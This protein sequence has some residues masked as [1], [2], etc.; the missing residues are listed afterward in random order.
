MANDNIHKNIR[1][2]FTE[3]ANAIRFKTGGTE[4]IKADEFPEAINAIRVEQIGTPP[5]D[6]EWL[7]DDEAVLGYIQHNIAGAYKNSELTQVKSYA[8][9]NQYGLTKVSFPECKWIGQSAFQ[10]CSSLTWVS[11]LTCSVIQSSAFQSC[12]SLQSITAPV[13]EVLQQY[14]F[15]QCQALEFVQMN[16]VKTIQSYAFRS[17]KNLKAITFPECVTVQSQAFYSCTSLSAVNLMKCTTIQ[18]EAF[19]Y[20]TGLVNVYLPMLTSVGYAAFHDCY[21]LETVNFPVLQSIDNYAFG[22][23][24]K[25]QYISLYEANG[26]GYA[27]FSDCKALSTVFMPKATQ[28]SQYMFSG[29]TSLASVSAPQVKTIGQQAF[30]N[31]NVLPYIDFPYCTVIHSQAFQKNYALSSY[32]LP[33]VTQI[34]HAAFSECSALKIVDFPLVKGSSLASHAFRQNIELESAFFSSLQWI[35]QQCFIGDWILSDVRIP[36]ALSIGSSAFRYCYALSNAAFPSATTIYERAFAEC[37]IL[38]IASF[39]NVVSLYSAAFYGCWNLEY[40]SFPKISYI[41]NDMFMNCSK[42]SFVNFN[43]A[44]IIGNRA[45]MG[46]SSLSVISEM[47]SASLIGL[48]AFAGTILSYVELPSLKFMPSYLFFTTETLS[49]CYFNTCSAMYPFAMANTGMSIIS[50]ANFPNLKVLGYYSSVADYWGVPTSMRSAFSGYQGPSSYYYGQQWGLEPWFRQNPDHA[51]RLR[52]MMEPFATSQSKFL[53]DLSSSPFRWAGHFAFNSKLTECTLPLSTIILSSCIFGCW[54]GCPNLELVSLP[55]LATLSIGSGSRI[56]S[57]FNYGTFKSLY[58]PL[59]ST[60]RSFEFA[61]CWRMENIYIPKLSTLADRAFLCCSSLSTVTS[62]M[63]SSVK[64]IQGWAFESC[65]NLKTVNLPA[66]TSISGSAFQYCSGLETVSVSSGYKTILSYTFQNCWSLSTLYMP[67]VTAINQYAFYW[68]HSLNPNQSLYFPGITNIGNI[69]YMAFGSDRN[70]TRYDPIQDTSRYHQDLF[71]LRAIELPNASGNMN[72][73]GPFYA[74]QLLSYCSIPLVKSLPNYAF[75]YCRS[76]TTLYCPSV[77]TVGSY[78][79]QSCESLED[80]NLP[81]VNAIGS[82][83]FENCY[84]LKSAIYPYVSIIQS[85]TF[86]N[87]S[88]LSSIRFTQATVI[89]PSAFQRCKALTAITSDTFPLASMIS[90]YAFVGCPLSMAY[91]PNCWYM[92]YRCFYSYDTNTTGGI[93]THLTLE[94][95]GLGKISSGMFAL[96]GYLNLRRVEFPELINTT[97]YLFYNLSKLT[98]VHL[99]KVKVLSNYTFMSCALLGTSSLSFSQVT[100]IGHMAFAYCHTLNGDNISFGTLTTVGPGSNIFSGCT[101]FTRIESTTFPVATSI[102]QSAFKSMPNLQYVNMPEVETIAPYA[103]YECYN[104]SEWHFPKAKNIN[105]AFWTTGTTVTDTRPSERAWLDSVESIPQS[106]G[107]SQKQQL[108]NVYAPAC[109]TIGPW[110]F[111]QT[112]FTELDE[113]NFPNVETIHYAAFASCSSLSNNVRLSKLTS[114]VGSTSWYYYYTIFYST[115]FKEITFDLLDVDTRWLGLRDGHPIEIIN[116]PE[117]KEAGLETHYNATKLK[118]FNAPKLERITSHSAFT[119]C[120]SLQSISFPLCST[121]TGNSVFYN[122]SSLSIV[123][124]P[125]LLSISGSYNF[126]GCRDLKTLNMPGLLR[127]NGSY[128]FYNCYNLETLNMPNL[129]FGGFC[130]FQ[131][132]SALK[133]VYLPKMSSFTI[134]AQYNEYHNLFAYCSNI[135]T[136][137]L[138]LKALEWRAMPGNS[139]KYKLKY[140]AF[141]EAETATDGALEYCYALEDFSLPKLQ[142]FGSRNNIS[143]IFEYCSAL[144]EIRSDHF[145]ALLAN[146]T[147]PSYTFQYCISLSKVH[148]ASTIT[149]VGSSAFYNCTSLHTVILDNVSALDRS[150]FHNCKNLMSLYILTSTMCTLPYYALHY[151]SPF[152][153]TPFEKSD[154]T[155]QFGSVYVPEELVETYKANVHWSQIASLITAYIP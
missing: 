41:G 96:S 83:A 24:S 46:C 100:S 137:T 5:G 54:E 2:L 32:Y 30:Q 88:S 72:G 38:Q 64:S 1:P 114:V 141:P 89:H 20:D 37:S 48:G 66:V 99:P 97:D 29:C 65:I 74:Q 3:I 6:P 148:L 27:A 144:T 145:P 49:Q 80:L 118:T 59:L 78:C 121:I 44:K 133:S 18:S 76:L 22:K 8:F 104:V 106:A 122:C 75:R 128:N 12:N 146:T 126:G 94:E 70:E 25:L 21:N 125:M 11:F 134:P 92:D 101:G 61:Y 47:T 132:C 95:I 40:A 73:Q 142:N 19:R 53:T 153:Q 33:S 124:M 98:D 55:S 62:E 149:K 127:I 35:P 105:Q 86:Q 10:N 150:V 143:G 31:C 28:I 107:F 115:I 50:I 102:A 23:C 14:A 60:V 17:C 56:N 108:T 135:E 136:M 129:E 81:I 119:Y 112:G 71:F 77:T 117:V 91:F 36:L 87:C 139:Q 147:L 45:F 9:H 113:T 140:L 120:S 90:E 79:F 42:L 69:H 138:G 151:S 68:C 110:A 58:L 15:E 111:Y 85:S 116:M 57:P 93:S 34:G 123:D 7:S 43:N 16:G 109:K 52:L 63:M 13:V 103:F 67:G 39:S 130:T 131:S 4:K 155:G 84:K 51:E 152:I 26:T 154:F 82:N